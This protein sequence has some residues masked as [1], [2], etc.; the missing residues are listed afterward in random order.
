MTSALMQLVPLLD[1]SNYPSWSSAMKAFL[2]SQ[3]LWRIT[4]GDTSYPIDPAATN[5]KFGDPLPDPSQEILEARQSWQK[6]NDAALSN[7]ILRLTPPLADAVRS[8]TAKE[9]WRYLQTAT[10]LTH[11]YQQFIFVREFQLD[12]L[13][14]PT[15]QIDY[16][17]QIYNQFNAVNIVIPDT[18]QAMFLLDSLPFAWQ[19]HIPSVLDELSSSSL[20]IESIQPYCLKWWI[21]EQKKTRKSSVA[22]QQDS[23]QPS[24]ARGKKNSPSSLSQRLPSRIEKAPQGSTSH[25]KTKTKRRT[26]AGKGKQ[27]APAHL[28]TDA[29]LPSPS[30]TTIAAISPNG[31]ETRI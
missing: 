9:A 26:R 1:G 17:I 14:H 31:I 23:S 25:S 28:A 20:S 27:R 6:K 19:H 2:M 15:P 12:Q 7:I 5:T 30:S 10:S 21:A 3:M 8:F 16:L 29:A 11:V 18:V 4:N 22:T 13:R 24:A